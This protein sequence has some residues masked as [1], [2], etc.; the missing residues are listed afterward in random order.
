M[1]I[2]LWGPEHLWIWV[3]PRPPEAIIHGYQR[4]ARRAGSRNHCSCYWGGQKAQEMGEDKLPHP[5]MTFS[6]RKTVGTN[7][8]LLRWNLPPAL[9]LRRRRGSSRCQ[10]VMWLRC[11]SQGRFQGLQ[12]LMLMSPLSSFLGIGSAVARE[13]SA[14]KCAQKR[15]LAF[16]CGNFRHHRSIR[17]H[18]FSLSFF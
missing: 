17:S 3:A 4:A 5:L 16:N 2:Y 1:L 15:E 8:G 12:G 11:G 14:E 10:T 9:D 18:L 13:D 6:W 7:M